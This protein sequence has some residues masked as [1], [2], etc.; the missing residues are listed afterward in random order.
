MDSLGKHFQRMCVCPRHH[1]GCREL[2][3]QAKFAQ[4]LDILEL[5]LGDDIHSDFRFL[6]IIF[7]SGNKSDG[8]DWAGRDNQEILKSCHVHR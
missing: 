6:K 1:S 2:K 5:I 8:V 3:P 4:F 7:L